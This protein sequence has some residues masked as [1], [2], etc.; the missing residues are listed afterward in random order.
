M[1]RAPVALFAL[2]CTLASSMVAAGVA[3][4]RPMTAGKPAVGNNQQSE[5]KTISYSG[6]V[7]ENWLTEPNWQAIDIERAVALPTKKMPTRIPE[8]VKPVAAIIITIEQAPA[9]A[10]K[11]VAKPAAAKPVAVQQPAKAPAAKPVAAQKP[12]VAAKPAAQK[13]VA[14][15]PA[16]KPEQAVDAVMTVVS[17]LLAAA[18]TAPIQPRV[19][20]SF[21]STY[22]PTKQAR[23][24][25]SNDRVS[26]ADLHLWK[27]SIATSNGTV[28]AL[29]I[30]EIAKTTESTSMVTIG[31]G[32][33]QIA[34]GSLN[35][36]KVGG[37]SFTPSPYIADNAASILLNR[38]ISTTSTSDTAKIPSRSGS[39]S[40]WSW[41]GTEL[42]RLHG[43]LM[44][45]IDRLGEQLSRQMNRAATIYLGRIQ[46]YTSAQWIPAFGTGSAQTIKSAQLNTNGKPSVTK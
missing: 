40:V 12:V 24:V 30:A 37:N 18:K 2:L 1:N 17:K 13:A 16:V 35:M 46:A 31:S 33:L 5:L 19:S 7:K 43:G 14:V 6:S 27:P 15:K 20:S 34:Y 10:A 32:R 23:G 22:M 36:I 3:S 38:G 42:N 39:F 21:S 41:T 29:P 25:L 4:D 44:Q 26:I 45:T 11:M 28:V 9:P 8:K